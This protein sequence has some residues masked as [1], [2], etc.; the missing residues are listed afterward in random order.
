M[1]KIK[2][3]NIITLSVLFIFTA[4]LTFSENSNTLNLHKDVT[5]VTAKRKMGKNSKVEKEILSRTIKSLPKL[6]NV[7]PIITK[8]RMYV[9]SIKGVDGKGGFI[10]IYT[11]K[12]TISYLLNLEEL[13]IVSPSSI[14]GMKPIMKTYNKI[15][16]KTKVFVSDT[17]NGDGF[18][19]SGGRRTYYF[20][21]SK[22]ASQDV[23]A[24][25]GSWLKEKSALLYHAPSHK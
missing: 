9:H 21:T 6:A 2:S 4:S 1:K 3:L 7:A 22:A 18:F 25:V 5:V 11:A 8:K 15:I 20:S 14:K 13:I 10:T 24:K 23:K 12:V 19:G 17:A 16:S